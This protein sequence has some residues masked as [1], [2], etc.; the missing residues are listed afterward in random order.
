MEQLNWIM[1]IAK[2]FGTLMQKTIVFC[3]TCTEIAAVLSYILKVLGE[4]AYTP[5]HEKCP[6]NRI[7][8]IYHS[9]TRKKYKDSTTAMRMLVSSK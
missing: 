3:N 7:M 6:S 5:C 9:T 1:D 8:A 2:E 4:A